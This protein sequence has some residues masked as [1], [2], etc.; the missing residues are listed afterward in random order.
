MCKCNVCNREISQIEFDNGM[1]EC[2]ECF[3]DT[4]KEIQ[5]YFDSRDGDGMPY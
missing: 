5:E 3:P 2:L 4:D 1:G